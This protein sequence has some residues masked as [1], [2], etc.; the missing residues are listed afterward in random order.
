MTDH[1]RLHHVCSL[2]FPI[3]ESANPRM[4]PTLHLRQ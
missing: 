3:L 2:L 4:P 1:Q